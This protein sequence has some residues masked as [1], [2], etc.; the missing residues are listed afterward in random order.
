LP[1]AIEDMHFYEASE[2]GMEE[3]IKLNQQR[4]RGQHRN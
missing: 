2:Q 3:K 4:R 1:S